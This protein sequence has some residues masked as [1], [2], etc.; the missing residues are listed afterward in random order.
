MNIE[1]PPDGHGDPELDVEAQF[2]QRAGQGA[3]QSTINKKC[4]SGW[5][6]CKSSDYI[7]LFSYP[8]P[9]YTQER[10]AMGSYFLSCQNR[11]TMHFHEYTLFLFLFIFPSLVSLTGIGGIQ[12]LLYFGLP[13]AM[14]VTG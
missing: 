8:C 5:C 7:A 3:R 10:V 1:P 13:V 2:S 12:V 14:I 11:H 9:H 6:W 4:L